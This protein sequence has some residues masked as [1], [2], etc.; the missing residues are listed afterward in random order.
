M[1]MKT[2]L[3]VQTAVMIV[4]VLLLICRAIVQ[5]S[6][7]D[8]VD[9][10]GRDHM[11]EVVVRTDKD[12]PDDPWAS[13]GYRIFINTQSTGSMSLS[14]S[15]GSFTTS[16]II[17]FIN[18]TTYYSTLDGVTYYGIH[19]YRIRAEFMY[20]TTTTAEVR[21]QESAGIAMLYIP[22]RTYIGNTIYRWTITIPSYVS[23][24]LRIYP[25]VR[26]TG[27][28]SISTATPSM[29]VRCAY[30]DP[31][32]GN[33]VTSTS[34]LS[35]TVVSRARVNI[36]H[37]NITFR[38]TFGSTWNNRQLVG[39]AVFSTDTSYIGDLNN[40]PRNMN[41][42]SPLLLIWHQYSVTILAGDTITYSVWYV[43]PADVS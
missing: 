36:T 23:P 41:A 8:P 21:L 16:Q 3:V 33:Q 29:T 12:P 7:G 32:T 43:A 17:Q 34:D 9:G 13:E 20:A 38:I 4:L 37:V 39:C 35:F 15:S 25:Y 5:P 18:V 42:A 11:F 26:P 24:T 27:V 2:R 31:S 40:V 19:F 6:A 22:T 1:G 28:S 14:T 30:I 10:L